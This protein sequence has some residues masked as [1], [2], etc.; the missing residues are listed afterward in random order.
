MMLDINSRD[1]L[2]CRHCRADVFVGECRGRYVLLDREPSTTGAYA[3]VGAG[4]FAPR[5]APSAVV[6]ASVAYT[7]HW[8]RCCQLPINHRE[9]AARWLSVP[10]LR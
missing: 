4:R 9:E 7:A 2:V 10:D 3:F 8:T 6:S 1:V 5:F